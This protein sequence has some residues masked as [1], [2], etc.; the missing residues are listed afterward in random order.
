MIL[1]SVCVVYI[2]ESY[3]KADKDSEIFVI[4]SFFKTISLN[5]TVD[6]S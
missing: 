5:T 4:L 2:G 3:I 1:N 6:A